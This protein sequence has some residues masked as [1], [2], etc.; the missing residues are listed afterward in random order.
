M[1][2]VQSKLSSLGF[3]E[4][5]FKAINGYIHSI[6]DSNKELFEKFSESLIKKDWNSC[7]ELINSAPD[8]V[9]EA[10]SKRSNTLL[11]IFNKIE[12]ILS[13][14]SETAKV[15]FRHAKELAEKDPEKAQ[16]I[17]GL[18]LVG[19]IISYLMGKKR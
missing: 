15:A 6:Y 13:M 19:I 10:I 11:T 7:R 12:E 3:G 16:Y 5:E 2:D 14:L 4:V 1:T 18:A 8:E 17:F 9:K